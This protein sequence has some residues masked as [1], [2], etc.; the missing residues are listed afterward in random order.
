MCSRWHLGVPDDRHGDGQLYIATGT[1]ASSSCFGKAGDLSVSLAALNTSDLSVADHW[2]IPTS[3]LVKDSDFGSVPTLFSGTVG[4]KSLKLV[5]VANKNGIFYAFDR[6]NLAAGPVWQVQ[7]AGA[8]GNPRTTSS[9]DPAV[10]DGST[11]YEGGGAVTINGTSCKGSV[12]AINPDDGSF[13]WQACLTDGSVV[14]PISAVPGV[15]SVTTGTGG[16]IVALNASN[17]AQLFRFKN[18]SGQP[19]WGGPTIADG[20]VF[21]NDMNA[22]LVA[23]ALPSVATPTPTAT[24]QP[25]ATSYEAESSANILVGGAKVGACSACSGGEKVRFVG[26]G[27]TLQFDGVNVAS[28]GSY[29]LTVDYV[30]GDAGRT[31]DM[32]ING[33]TAIS[34]TFHGTN[35]ANWNFVQSLTVTVTLKA[36]TNTVLFSNPSAFAPDF[37]RITIS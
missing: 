13:K 32:S 30:D 16:T 29:S 37:D 24:P 1:Q 27:G 10:W 19:Y 25:G 12:R 6:S 22:D 33:S 35:D 23:L 11:L 34:L 15:I 2:Q 31:G 5:G 7:V 3:Q 8:A 9:I 26:N 17:G 14:G 21:A 28:A 4:G 36:G 20:R 18:A